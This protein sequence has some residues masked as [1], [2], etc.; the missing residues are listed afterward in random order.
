HPTVNTESRGSSAGS[1]EKTGGC[2]PDGETQEAPAA[3]PTE[4]RDPA[5]GPPGETSPIDWLGAMMASTGKPG[6]FLGRYTL[7]EQLGE[8]GFGVVWRAEQKE[9]VRREVA[10]KV[11]KLG[12]DSR[13]VVGRFEAERQALALMDHPNIAHMLEGGATENGR[14]YFAMELVTGE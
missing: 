3:S 6:E 1:S 12:M 4:R 2:S 14:P 9:P 11:I 5:P 8:G 7:M 10:L 13:E